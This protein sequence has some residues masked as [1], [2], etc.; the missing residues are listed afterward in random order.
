MNEDKLFSCAFINNEIED[1]KNF[2]D[3]IYHNKPLSKKRELEPFR[4]NIKFFL[5]IYAVDELIEAPFR[6]WSMYVDK[7]VYLSK[8]LEDKK[9]DKK[10]VEVLLSTAY[11]PKPNELLDDLAALYFPH[12]IIDHNCFSSYLNLC[13]DLCNHFYYNFF[14]YDEEFINTGN[15]DLD[16]VYKCLLD[17]KKEGFTVRYLYN[18]RKMISLIFAYCHYNDIKDYSL[19][20]EYLNNIIYY[21]DKME[22]N[23]CSIEMISSIRGKN[24]YDY[25]AAMDIFYNMD[26]FFTRE[27]IAIK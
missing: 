11:F 14:E 16:L 23:K 2:I 26:S 7:A 17:L 21:K 6:Y 27:S 20:K 9:I 18:E 1:Y 4:K 5:K 13:T 10:L 15:T 22:L 3:E 12:D 19:I 24:V 8:L 25:K